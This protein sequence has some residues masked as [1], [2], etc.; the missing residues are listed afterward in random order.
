M[1]DYEPVSDTTLAK[2]ADDEYVRH[3]S[4][5]PSVARELLAARAELADLRRQ[6]A[7]AIGKWSYV[8]EWGIGTEAKA[9]VSWCGNHLRGREDRPRVGKAA[10]ART[11]EIFRD[12]LIEMARSVDP[13]RRF[14]S[15]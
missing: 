12:V 15:G 2:F 7:D 13:D 6:L 4:W 11:P 10:A 14:A 3:L 5:V 8:V 1:S 9:L